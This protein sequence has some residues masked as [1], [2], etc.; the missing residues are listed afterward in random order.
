MNRKCI[1]ILLLLLSVSLHAQTFGE[2]D[3]KVSQYPEFA[4]LQDLGIRIQND[5]RADSLRIRAAFT[6]LTQHITY[7]GKGEVGE[8]HAQRISYSS[9]KEKQEGIQDMV[10]V[11]INKAFR[12][13]KGV[14]IDYS[15]MLNALFEQFGLP[16]RIITGVAK[17]EIKRL[18]T[19]PTYRNHSWNA[20]QLHG[21]WKLM[22]ATWASGYIDTKS[23][24]FVRKFHDH[25][26]FTD[27][28]DFA[29][30]HLP[31]NKEWQ[32]LDQPID[33]ATFY[34]AP[35]LLPDFCEKGIRLSSRTSGILTLSDEKENIIYFDQLPRDHLMHYTIDGS[36]EYRRLG[37]KKGEGNGYISKIRLKKR[38]NRPYETLTVY[39]NDDPI[40]HFR[41]QEDI[42]QKAE[43]GS[44]K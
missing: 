7:D 42:P 26:F 23:N 8:H 6:W 5:F 34:H 20:V 18:D 21:S 27:P 12:L 31:A 37:F 40:L 38:F 14:C 2:V 11:K 22:D 9:E 15:L 19:H 10:W 24:K 43:A 35:I 4:S 33:A 36:T 17:T 16:S 29:R 30:H 32:L 1:T 3:R 28:A 25:Y 39:M 41:I 13:R 44:S